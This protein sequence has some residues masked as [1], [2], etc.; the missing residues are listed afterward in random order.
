MQMIGELKRSGIQNNQAAHCISAT[1]PKGQ[2]LRTLTIY[3][4]LGSCR[5]G[6]G[7]SVTQG[8]RVKKEK[9]KLG[10]NLLCPLVFEGLIFFSS[11]KKL[12]TSL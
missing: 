11:L 4:D 7:V 10:Q 1:Y 8:K 6:P 2:L 5:G 9:G 3:Q 12:T